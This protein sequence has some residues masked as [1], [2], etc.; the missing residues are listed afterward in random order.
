M[1]ER[2]ERLQF[3]KTFLDVSKI[4]SFL[5]YIGAKIQKFVYICEVSFT[6]DANLSYLS[7]MP[8]YLRGGALTR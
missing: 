5:C 3:F 4:H 6:N 1:L 2:L 8:L 7:Q